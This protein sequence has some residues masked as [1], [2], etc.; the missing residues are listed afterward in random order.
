MD[1][2][3]HVGSM[4]LSSKANV[5]TTSLVAINSCLSLFIFHF[6]CREKVTMGRRQR[7]RRETDRDSQAG[8]TLSLGLDP[9]GIPRPWDYDLSQ[10]RSTDRATQVPL[11]LIFEI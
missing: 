5:V 6:M 7:E 8:S 1:S 3:Q 4:Y 9:K 11:E 10:N 2:V